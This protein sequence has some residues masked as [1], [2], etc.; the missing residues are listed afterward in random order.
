MN[1]G[2]GLLA[3]ILLFTLVASA[4]TFTIKGRVLDA[5]TKEGLPFC[6]VYFQGTTIG[7]A[8]D[9]NGYYEIVAKTLFDTLSA[10]ALGYQTLRKALRPDTLQIVDFFLASA[11][12]D[13]AEVVVLAG[14]NPAHAV[15]RGI[16]KNKARNRLESLEAYQC[17]SYAK[18]ELDLENID[19][20]LRR[21]KLLKPF[22]FVF[23]NMDSTSDEKPFLPIYINEVIADI[24]YLKSASKVKT[25]LRAQR[26]S[27]TDNE[28][29][30]EYI[31]KIHAPFSIYDNWIYV[32]EKGFASPFADGALNYYEYYIIDSA[33]VNGYWSYQLKFK[34]KRR[35]EAT[36]YG[37][38]WVA[39]S[40]FA[41]HRVNMRMSPEVNI[42]LVNRIIIYQEFEPDAASR[43]LPVL[44]KM[45]VDFSPGKDTPGMIGRRTETFKQ[46][47]INHENIKNVYNKS[48]PAFYRQQELERDDAFWE[49]AR[50]VPLTS[51]ES[52][53]YSMVDSIKNVPLYKTYTR[54]ADIVL[55]GYFITGSWELGPYGSLYSI[56]PVEQHRFRIGARTSTNFSKELRLGA[57]IAYGLQDEEFK[58]GTDFIWVRS[59]YPRRVIGGAYKNDISINSESSEDFVESDFFSGTLRRNVPWKLIR[60]E[61]GKLYYERYWKNGFSN[62]ITLLHR[63]MDPY[64]GLERVGFPYAY[65]RDTEMPWQIDSTIST[66]EMIFKTRFVFDETLIDGTFDRTSVGTKHPIIELQYALGINGFLDGDYNY[67]RISLSYRHYVNINPIGW[68]SYRFKAGKVFGTVPF[69]LLEVHPGN[70]GFFMARGIFNTM[71]RYEFASDT[72]AQLVLEHHWDGFFFNKVPLLRKLKWREVMTFKAVSGSISDSN[73][74]ANQL[75]F[76]NPN[77]TTIYNGFRAP[78]RQPYMEAGIGIENIFKVIRLDALWRLSYLDNPQATR[79]TMVGG[80]YFFF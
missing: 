67:H 52:A 7:V 72:Y 61:E 24:Y 74:Q 26:T 40:T 27:G 25:L 73:L 47:I 10:S 14:E 64:N 66:T 36:F 54:I 3:I 21:S 77:E 69:L 38:F 12:F 37:D 11:N 59:R 71:N 46:F 39:D 31:K 4:Q 35:Q 23:E 22:E 6:N 20:K 42:N 9:L 45:I 56:N 65:L 2:H 30:I 29:I 63:N 16:I 41:I 17:E 18:V 33:Y 75:N 13:L 53:V 8:T 51:T 49:Q 44:Q 32:L 58:Y 68:L 80:L 55:N 70:E 34:P 43:W 57:Y 60:V 19:E 50:H 1:R 62:R 48:D 28:T 79:F 15:V 76:F 78:N 5:D